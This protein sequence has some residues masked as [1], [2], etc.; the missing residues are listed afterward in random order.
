MTTGSNG[1]DLKWD[2]PFHAHRLVT[3]R[4]RLGLNQGDVAR[5]LGVDQSTVSRLERGEMQSPPWKLVIQACLHLNLEPHALLD[6]EPSPPTNNCHP[7]G[8]VRSRLTN[9]FLYLGSFA[10]LPEMLNFCLQDIARTRPSVIGL[11]LI[12]FEW[13]RDATTR[14]FY[15]HWDSGQISYAERILDEQHASELEMLHAKWKRNEA[16]QRE[17]R[18]ELVGWN[19]ALAVDVPLTHG[20]FGIDFSADESAEPDTMRWAL[21][22]RDTFDSG[23]GLVQERGDGDTEYNMRQ[24]LS[25]MSAL[26]K[27][28]DRFGV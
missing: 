4:R 26:E 19:P 13:P 7:L 16:S 22:L 27:R 25:R 2:P 8:M 1:Q 9:H 28:F 17:G 21:K 24:L 14:Q 6:T 12:I 11:S 23:L 20:M 18:Q 15:A 3:A 5:L 10:R